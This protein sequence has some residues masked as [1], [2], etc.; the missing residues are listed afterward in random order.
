MSIE[1]IQKVGSFQGSGNVVYSNLIGSPTAGDLWFDYSNVALKIYNG[2]IWT[3]FGNST[4]DI[5]GVVAGNGLSGGGLSGTVTLDLDLSELT[6]MTGSITGSTEFILLDGATESR[7]AASEI[8]LSAFNNDSGWTDNAGTV[9]S[10]STTGTVNGITLSGGEI[11]DTG[12]VTLGG[13][14]ADVRLDQLLAANVITSGES[15]VDTD[16]QVMTAAA[17]NDRIESFGYTTNTGTVSSVSTAGSVN[18]ITLTGGDITSTGTITLGG[19]LGSITLSQLDSAALITSGEGFSDTDSAVLTAAAT[20]DRIQSYGYSTTVGTVTSIDVAGGNGLTSAGGPITDSG[21]VTLTVGAGPGIIANPD[22]VAVDVS[23]I[24]SIAPQGT[25]DSVTDNGNTTSNAITVGTLNTTTI[26][27]GGT[28]V[29]GSID[30]QWT[31]TTGSTFQATYADLAEKY[32]T[33]SEYEAGTVMKF[34][35]EAELTQSDTSNDHRVAGV[36]STNPAYILNADIDGQYLALTGRV[37][38]K[39]I[40]TVYPGDILVSSSAPGH[41][42]VNNDARSGRIIGK[43]ITADANGVCEALVTLM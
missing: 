6:D 27:S 40:G 34:G 43:A 30:G 20:D 15:F 8:D 16:G 38:V 25:L 18:G 29:S 32:T 14:L 21:T 10:V 24:E 33:D 7:K 5:S 9:T 28:A 17:I 39:V 22:N 12:T 23:F 36:V 37:P 41:A 11:T 4:G 35:G 19:T 31:L 26:S 42:E 1:S 3:Q 2:T 13:A